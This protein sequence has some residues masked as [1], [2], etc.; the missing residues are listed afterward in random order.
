[1]NPCHIFLSQLPTAAHGYA[2]PW[3]TPELTEPSPT[4]EEPVSTLSPKRPI[5]GDR[6]AS[7]W[8]SVIRSG[9]MDLLPH[10]AGA[11]SARCF[12]DFFVIALVPVSASRSDR[13][14]S[15]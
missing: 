13:T 11:L 10:L 6:V 7:A 1:M 3:E 14:W 9:R 5:P 8:N 2:M 15:P 12:P 4:L